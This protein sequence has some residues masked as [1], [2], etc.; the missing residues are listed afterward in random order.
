MKL[1]QSNIQML[2]FPKFQSFVL[3]KVWKA[4]LIA[5]FDQ[6]CIQIS[7]IA[8]V[9]KYRFKTRNSKLFSECHRTV[10]FTRNIF[11]CQDRNAVFFPLHSCIIIALYELCIATLNC[12]CAFFWLLYFG[13]FARKQ[14]KLRTEIIHVLY[15]KMLHFCFQY[16]RFYYNFFVGY[17]ETK[18]E[19]VQML[20]Q[21]KR[22]PCM[23]DV[24]Q[25]SSE[26]NKIVVELRIWPEL[27][28]EENKYDLIRNVHISM[29]IHLSTSKNSFIVKR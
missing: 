24:R 12:C 13:N 15:W 23:V 29:D 18:R 3:Y 28:S 4:I 14:F 1:A 20:A 21:R 16:F 17:G 19:E 27:N 10:A 5:A 11:K 26:V 8:G 22:R 6:K 9:W 7:N 25:M 2:Q